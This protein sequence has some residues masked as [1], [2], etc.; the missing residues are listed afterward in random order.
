MARNY[1]NIAADTTL[2]AGILAGDLSLVV[3]SAA[4]WPLAPFAAVLDPGGAAEEVVQVTVKAGTTWTVTRGFDGTTAAAHLAGVTVRHAAIAGDF[5]DL[6]AADTT[7]AG[8]LTT[9]AALTTTAHGGI[10]ASTDPRLTDARTPTGAAGG[11]LSGTYP[12]PGFAVDMATQAELNTHE[13]DS[14]N[15]HGIADTSALLTSAAAAAAYQPLDADLTA[16][17]ALTTTAYGR[18]LLELLDAAALRTAGG[19]GSLAVLSSIT[20]SLISDASANGRSLITA[21]DYAAM[22]V[23]LGLVIGTNVQAFDA[24]LAAL[25]GLTSAADKLPYFTGSGTAALADLSA[26]I[27]TLTGAADAVAARTT[28]GRQTRD[29]HTIQ[30][31][32]TMTWSS[33][34]AALDDF[35]GASSNARGRADMTNYLEVRL[36]CNVV[37]AG[38]AGAELRAQYSTDGG[39]AWNYFS[40]TT[41]AIVIDSTGH[42]VSSWVTIPGGALGDYLVRIIGILGNGATSPQFG[43]LKIQAR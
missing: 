29:L 32:S 31:A 33:M 9:H 43:T 5:T 22:R 35:R 36:A 39:G 17:A 26:Y 11:V 19:L 13:A 21:A 28:L 23:L 2:N 27:R 24:E 7:N 4:G 41:P 6:Q 14:T 3:V 8:N 18:A 15:V 40:G 20:A 25:A 38:F 30:D 12:N 16:I 10:V 34:P 37:V 42:K 1:S